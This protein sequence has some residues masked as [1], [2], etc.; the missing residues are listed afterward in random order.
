MGSYLLKSTIAFSDDL[1]ADKNIAVSIFSDRRIAVPLALKNK[2]GGNS[3]DQ[4]NTSGGGFTGSNPGERLTGSPVNSPTRPPTRPPSTSDLPRKDRTFKYLND[5]GL[6]DYSVLNNPSTPEAKAANWIANE[7][8][9]NLEIP[10]GGTMNRFSERWALAVIYFSTGGDQWR[11]KLNFLQPIDHCDWYDRF[12]DPNG[13][14]IRQG[15]TEC[16]RFDQGGDEMV[17]KL[18]ICKFVVFLEPIARLNKQIL[19]LN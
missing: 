11:Y 8:S 1:F 7:D 5:F 19:N 4:S 17:T 10:Q 3:P 15:V 18:E 12:V 14:I 13:Y 6:A 9:F 16:Q 2:G